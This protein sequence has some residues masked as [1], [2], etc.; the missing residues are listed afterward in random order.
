MLWGKPYEYLR[1]QNIAIHAELVKLDNDE[2]TRGINP[3]EPRVLEEEGAWA[4]GPNEFE[5][6][7]WAWWFQY[8]ITHPRRGHFIDSPVEGLTVVSPTY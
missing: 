4:F 6:A 2:Q 8:E 7:R 3:N 5:G 1:L